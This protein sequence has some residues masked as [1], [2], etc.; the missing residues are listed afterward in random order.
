MPVKLPPTRRGDQPAAA[1]YTEEMSIAA[2]SVGGA[3]ADER[4]I[5]VVHGTDV[6]VEDSAGGPVL[7]RAERVDPLLAELTGG[8]TGELG[9]GGGVQPIALGRSAGRA[10][11]G[12]G[13]SAAVRAAPPAGLSFV[14]VRALLGV[15][16]QAAL[17]V[18]GRAIAL[19]EFEGLHRFCGRCAAATEPKAG[20]RARRCPSCGATFHPG[21]P[22][23]VIVVVE[24]DDGRIL[25]ARNARF[26]P[27]MFSAVAGFVEVGESLEQ[28]VCR[29]VA[30]EVGIRIDRLR[31][32][33]SQPWPFGRSLMMGFLARYAGGEIAVDGAEIAEARWFSPNDLPILPS[34]V[35]IARRMIDAW[36]TAS[37]AP[38]P[39]GLTF[40]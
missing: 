14:P 17:D 5:V 40:D 30:E 28:A 15:W 7:P 8:L 4:L 33:G 27:G 25:L 9:A 32:F 22:P 36:M 2:A 10:C 39:G 31:Y 6:L 3:A 13:A 1:R 12:A 18:V 11:F 21:I 23:A 16:D 29:E 19:V 26:P 24:R 35:S 37:S 38:G 20:E 34:R